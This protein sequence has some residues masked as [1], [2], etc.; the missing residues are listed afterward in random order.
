MVEGHQNN[1]TEQKK[2]LLHDKGKIY[3]SKE[4]E[5]KIFFFLTLIMLL[6][7]VLVKAGLF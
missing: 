2:I 7:G 6:T 5:R 1:R 4:T 3:F